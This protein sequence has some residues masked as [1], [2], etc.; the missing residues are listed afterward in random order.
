MLLKHTVKTNGEDEYVEVKTTHT[1]QTSFVMS[2]AEFDFAM[3][4]SNNYKLYLIV[5]IGSG[6]DSYKIII[7]N[8]REEYAKRLHSVSRRLIYD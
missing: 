7:E 2:D 1:N 5:N 8:F 4:N 3:K 6:P